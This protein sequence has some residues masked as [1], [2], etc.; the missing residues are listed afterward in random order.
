MGDEGGEGKLEE[1]NREQGAGSREAQERKGMADG[2]D[3]LVRSTT[4]LS[5]S[6]RP[7]ASKSIRSSGQPLPVSSSAD[8]TQHPQRFHRP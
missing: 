4:F 5:S 2:E 1:Q 6:S 8:A 3:H 7:R